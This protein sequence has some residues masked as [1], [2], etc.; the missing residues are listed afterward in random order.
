M[1][2]LVHDIRKASLSQPIDVQLKRML[3]P[4]NGGRKKFPTLLLYDEEGLKLYEEL[5]YL[6]EYYL[7]A[8]EFDA[9][10]R[11]ANALAGQVQAGSILL[12]L[13]SGFEV[14]DFR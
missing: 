9:L 2:V 6:D 1:T 14:T 8:A 3:N 10:T 11:H 12:E 7:L 13:G 4:Q 5:T